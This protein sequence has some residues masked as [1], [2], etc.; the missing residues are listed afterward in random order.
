VADQGNSAGIGML[1]PQGPG[2]SEFNRPFQVVNMP[3]GLAHDV[4][5]MFFTGGRGR[6]WATIVD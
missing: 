5:Y 3:T 1:I 2:P 6:T 4:K